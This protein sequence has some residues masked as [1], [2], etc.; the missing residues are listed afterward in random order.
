[1]V[2]GRAERNGDGPSGSGGELLAV[3]DLRTWFDTPIGTVKAVNGVSLTLA[4]GETLGLVGE[5]GSGKSVLSRSVSRLVPR[6]AR[7]PTGSVVFDDI[8]LLASS[9][10]Q[11][12]RFWGQD[13]AMV[14]QDPMTSLN[15]VV[16]IGRQITESL[17]RHLEMGKAA[18]QGKAVEL[19]HSVG[20]PEPEKRA[21]A[22]PHE[23]SGGMRQRV[24]IAIALACDPK[25]LIAD[26]PTTALDVTVQEQILNLLQQQT[27]ERTMAMILVSHDLG[28]MA[29]RTDR[30]AVMYAGR[31]VEL[32]PTRQL[33]A[34]PR[35][36]Y[37]EALLQSIPNIENPSHTRLRMIPGS[38]PN[39]LAPPKGCAF[40]ARCAYV[41][42]RCREETPPLQ[43]AETEGHEFA[44]FYPVGTSE[45]DAALARNLGTKETA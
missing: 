45:G 14:F 18:A 6:T 8:D 2:N 39:M 17:R 10:R 42:D 38:P 44:C 25:L 36:P 34:A 23:L 3:G 11:L 1:M 31:V 32:A 12:R 27:E 19:L 22:Y 20:I 24:T 30:I 9:P 13:I 16:K 41:Q 40:A 21:Q 37:T 28:V 5:S 26:E 4:R 43:P 33:F 29:G 7:H 35:M 15:P